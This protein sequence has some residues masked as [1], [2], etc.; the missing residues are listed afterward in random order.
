VK[1]PKKCYLSET[2]FKNW[3]RPQIKEL[4][5]VWAEKI[6]Q[7]GIHGTPDFLMSVNGHFVAMEIKRSDREKTT[8][9]QLF[10]LQNIS[11]TGG[12]ALVCYPQNWEATYAILTQL[13]SGGYVDK[14]LYR[15]H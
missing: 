1:I 7:V 15:M 9:L 13:A 12:V 8:P 4:P 5:N 14:E 11:R 2:A 3:I 6:Q 10:N